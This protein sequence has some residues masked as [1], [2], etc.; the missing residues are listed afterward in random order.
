[1][2]P[3]EVNWWNMLVLYQEYDTWSEER[4]NVIGS[5]VTLQVLGLT[6][7][8]MDFLK[9]PEQRISRANVTTVSE[10][11]HVFSINFLIVH[12]SCLALFTAH[13]HFVK[14]FYSLQNIIL[15][16]SLL[17]KTNFC[18]TNFV[19]FDQFAENQ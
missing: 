15:N 8:Y 12:F 4:N 19:N 14:S 1:M 13:L 6:H 2:F 10:V 7:F 3:S 11:F 9:F 16:M 17:L 18:G 5:F